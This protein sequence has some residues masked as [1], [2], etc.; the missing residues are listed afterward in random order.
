MTEPVKNFLQRL[1]MTVH[2]VHIPFR[3]SRQAHIRL[4][5][6]DAAAPSDTTEPYGDRPFPG[7]YYGY[8]IFTIVDSDLENHDLRV[9][10]IMHLTA[11]VNNSNELTYPNPGS[12]DTYSSPVT[13][14]WDPIPNLPGQQKYRVE[15]YFVDPS[16]PDERRIYN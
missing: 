3:T 8:Q 9:D 11:P 2:M 1:H 5:F 10:Q 7:D 16:L 15:V 14:R 13:F 12:Y 6:I 4:I